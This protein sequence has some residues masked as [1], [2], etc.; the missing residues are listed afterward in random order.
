MKIGETLCK[1]S[2]RGAIKEGVPSPRHV[3]TLTLAAEPQCILCQCCFSRSAERQASRPSLDILGIGLA[4]R[5]GNAQTIVE[6]VR[7]WG[8]QPMGAVWKLFCGS[9]GWPLPL[10]QGPADRPPR[11]A[12]G[13]RSAIPEGAVLVYS[14]P[15]GLVRWFPGRCMQRRRPGSSAVAVERLR[16]SPYMILWHLRTGSG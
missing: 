8:G 5:D 13:G 7:T 9:I 12:N 1:C 2:V 6:T 15:F 4:A 14:G 11:H 10:H 3:D 16:Q